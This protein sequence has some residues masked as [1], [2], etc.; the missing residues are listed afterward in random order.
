MRRLT[1][2]HPIGPRRRCTKPMKPRKKVLAAFPQGTV[3]AESPPIREWLISGYADDVWVFGEHLPGI[4]PSHS[5]LRWDYGTRDGGRLTDARNWRWLETIKAATWWYRET[6][7][8]NSNR[9][10]SARGLAM[11]LRII[12]VW[13]IDRGINSPVELAHEDLEDFVAHIMS[14]GVGESTASCKLLAW[15]QLWMLRD[16]LPFSLRADPYPVRGELKSV[17]RLAGKQGTHT[18]S[19]VPRDVFRCFDAALKWLDRVE[20]I[21]DA[22]NLVLQIVDGYSEEVGGENTNCRGALIT[23]VLEIEMKGWLWLAT[24][25]PSRGATSSDRLRVELGKCYGALLVLL[26]GFVAFRKH[27]AAYLTEECVELRGLMPM[28]VGTVR[29]SSPTPTGRATER[30]IHE[31]VVR[32]VSA[33][34]ALVAD[35]RAHGSTELLV[36]DPVRSGQ[37]ER[38]SRPATSA[39]MYSVMDGFVDSVGLELP[40]PLRPHMLRRAFCL[41]HMWRYELGDLDTLSGYLFHNAREHT[42]RYIGIAEAE[43]YLPEAQQSL[44]FDL[45]YRNLTGET[46]LVGGFAEWLKRFRD[47][48]RAVVRVL[49]LERIA[50][51]VRRLISRQQLDIVPGAHGYCIRSPSRDQLAQCSTDGKVPDY[52]NRTDVHCARC[53]NFLAHA[54]FQDHWERMLGV[55][56]AVLNDKRVPHPLAEAAARGVQ[57]CRRILSRMQ[58]QVRDE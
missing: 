16:H 12:A 41:L 37:Y 54:G 18:L 43:R 1:A 56:R 48:L 45:L 42:V 39:Y 50:D 19:L 3:L 38:G 52:W 22:R 28:L 4:P 13:A 58:H 20:Q 32:V 7:E 53:P 34:R 5:R 33:L 17:A 6:D 47:R 36:T 8:N 2:K 30:A 44:L 46:E 26:F 11:E 51:A 14:L 27:E 10:S 31:V 25:P 29:K 49:P 35:I 23:A 9:A 40:R 57:A 21:R 55:H 15:R 24:E